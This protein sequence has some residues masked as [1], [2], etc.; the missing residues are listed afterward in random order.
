[1]RPSLRLRE[2]VRQELK[3]FGILAQRNTDPALLRELLNDLYT[4]QL[5]RLRDQLRAGAFPKREYASRVL[6][7]RQRYTLL[8]LP[9]SQWVEPAEEGTSPPL[10]SQET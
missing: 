2:S 3:K 7:I 5:R 4:Y 8:S 10:L 6:A 1:M 9:L